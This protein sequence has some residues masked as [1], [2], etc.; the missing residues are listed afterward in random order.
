MPLND[1]TK[2]DIS[3]CMDPRHADAFLDIVAASSSQRS[4]ATRRFLSRALLLMY[5][6]VSTDLGPGIRLLFGTLSPVITSKELF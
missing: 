1:T 5:L 6:M 2:L 4:C 3:R